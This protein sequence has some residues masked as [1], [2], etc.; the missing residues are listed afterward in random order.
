MNE[1]LFT[2]ALFEIILAILVSVVIIY[3]SYSILHRLFFKNIDLKGGN[4]AFTVFTSGIVLS[5]GLILSEIIPSITN[6]VRL[7]TTQTDAIDV[8]TIVQYGG[9]YLLIGFLAAVIINASVFFLFSILTRGINE[10]QAIKD[11][12]MSVSILVVATLLSITLIVKDSIALLIS[13]I[14]P[15]P[16]VSNFL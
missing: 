2:L 1:K 14:I 10:F 13:S 9:L 15:Y 7:S 16:E 12:N 5:I 8:G 11:D 6:M 4:A 3:I